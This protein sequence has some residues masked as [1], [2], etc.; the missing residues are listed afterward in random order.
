MPFFYICGYKM[1][2]VTGDLEQMIESAVVAAGVDYVGYELIHSGKNSILRV[3]V[4]EVNGIDINTIEKVSRQISAVLNV[5]RPGNIDYHLEVSSPGLDR[6]LFRINDYRRFIGS[7][8]KLRLKMP[9]ENNRRH[10]RGELMSVE[11]QQITIVVE[12]GEKVTVHF[13]EIEKA[14]LVPEF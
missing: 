6:P 8:I 13:D 14:N 2:A 9:K 3:Y 1:T 12:S 11:N 10:Y 5:E 4:D 7:S